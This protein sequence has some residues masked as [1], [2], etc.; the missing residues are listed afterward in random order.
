[1]K[2]TSLLTFGLLVFSAYQS[3]A[4]TW[5]Q[6]SDMPNTPTTGRWN[7]YGFAI[8]DK[9]YM[10]GGY[11]GNGQSTK[12][13]WEYDMAT[14]SW[15]QKADVP[16]SVNRTAAISFSI[17]GKGYVGLGSRHYNTVNAEFLG[18]LW[19]YD[20]GL[21]TWTQKASLPDSARFHAACFVI[22]DKAYVVGGKTGYPL[23][24]S[25]DLWI[26]DPAADQWDTGH[27]YPAHYIYNAAAFSLNGKGYVIGGRIHDSTSANNYVTNATWEYDPL[28][29]SW[30]AKAP[31]LDTLGRENAVAFVYNNEGYVGLGQA[32]SG[33]I[34]YYYREFGK[35][36]PVADDWDTTVSFAG[37]DRAYSLAINNGNRVFAGGGFLYLSTQ[38]YFDDW[39]E[40]TDPSW[41]VQEPGSSLT[42]L[43][44]PNPAGNQINVVT[45]INGSQTYRLTDLQGR[46]VLSGQQDFSAAP[47]LNIA[48][49]EAGIYVLQ[50]GKSNNAQLLYKTEAA[51]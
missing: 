15:T 2:K 48:I 28:T 14:D 29:D 41:G 50:L 12:D 45:D 17:N 21:N 13:L 38:T 19:E 32:Y 49:L 7:P 1:M 25:H 11:V 37:M 33:S 8:N 31:Y 46:E 34:T 27:I 22:D 43:V 24:A 35:Y 42:F 30:T 10:G 47:V 39:W 6:R 18:D 44:Y 51:K 5:V 9:I 26:Y 20:P 3:P 40:F 4:Q 23:S 16:G 36:D